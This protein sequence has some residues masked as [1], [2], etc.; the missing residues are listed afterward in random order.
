MNIKKILK[1]I[2]ANKKF[3][4]G[5]SYVHFVVYDEMDLLMNDN[6]EKVY[7]TIKAS[8]FRQSL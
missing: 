4:V 6:F 3:K 7:L 2:N 8:T 1:H 5:R